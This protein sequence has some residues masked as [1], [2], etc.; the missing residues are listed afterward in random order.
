ME[1]RTAAFDRKR[2]I[3]IGMGWLFAAGGYFLA[4]HLFW[5]VLT[6]LR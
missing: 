2:E 1:T 3:L 4:Y 5:D 6:S